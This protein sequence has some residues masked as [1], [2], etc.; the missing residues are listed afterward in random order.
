[1]GVYGMDAYGINKNPYTAARTAAPQRTNNTPGYGTAKKAQK[2]AGG[3]FPL[4]GTSGSQSMV[5]H[6]FDHE[7]GEKTIGAWA[8]VAAGTS[9]S[10]YE[11]KGFDPENPVYKVKIWDEAGNVEE[12]SIAIADIDPG[13]ADT[14]E[15]YTLASHASHTGK[16]P[17][18]QMTFMMAHVR[19][20]TEGEEYTKENLFDKMNWFDFFSDIMKEQYDLGNMQGYLR[21]K[22]FYDYLLDR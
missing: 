13:S 3:T 20:H 14:I 6:V 5:L 15:M 9:V 12:R 1:M 19:T 16:D 11:P 18:A 17:D 8:D 21:Y 4:A 7:E 10:V 2:Q 22:G